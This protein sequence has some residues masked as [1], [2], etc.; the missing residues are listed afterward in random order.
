MPKEVGN[1][2]IEV[3]VVSLGWPDMGD[4]FALPNNRDAFKNQLLKTHP[5][6][7]AGAIPV[8]AGTLYKFANEIKPGD[9]IVYPSKHD[10]TVNIGVVGA[11][12]WHAPL[13]KA[14]AADFPNHISVAWKGH[15]REAISVNP[16]LMRLA[17]L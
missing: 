3:W 4:I 14:W 13:R 9:V 15:F 16:L 10:R 1:D 8:D 11:K 2:P 12:K 5:G 6:T 17:R 7:K